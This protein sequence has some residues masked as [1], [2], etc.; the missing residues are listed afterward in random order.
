MTLTIPFADL[1]I[2]TP[3]AG[4]SLKAN[5]YRTRWV[6]G[7]LESSA[8]TPTNEPDYSVS[9]RFGTLVLGGPAGANPAGPGR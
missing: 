8:W 1:G 3:T 6:G 7:S 2:A 9:K 5:I 4:L